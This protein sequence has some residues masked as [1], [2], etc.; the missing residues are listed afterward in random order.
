MFP[1]PGLCFPR[2]IKDFDSDLQRAPWRQNSVVGRPRASSLH[3]GDMEAARAISRVRSKSV[4]LLAQGF[5]PAE[6][7]GPLSADQRGLTPS[8]SQRALLGS[9]GGGPHALVPRGSSFRLTPPSDAGDR[10]AVRPSPLG[11]PAGGVR[12][13]GGVEDTGGRE[14]ERGKGVRGS[15]RADASLVDRPFWDEALRTKT[16]VRDLSL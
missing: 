8:M 15:E 12:A 1:P 7:D 13:R 5:G 4:I 3:T 10:R 6:Q 2:R 14:G 16:E 9:G 11:T